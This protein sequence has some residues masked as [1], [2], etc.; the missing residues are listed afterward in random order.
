M[1]AALGSSPDAI[2]LISWNEYSENSQI[3][4]SELY[5]DTALKVTAELTG[6]PGAVI[7]PADSSTPVRSYG[8]PNGAAALT[9]MVAFLGALL[10]LSRWR[11]GGAD[12]I[13]DQP[14]HVKS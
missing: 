13:S 14:R 2:G 12:V 9:V 10:V 7:T 1:N 8:G 11:R 6:A 5:G 4:P 3:E